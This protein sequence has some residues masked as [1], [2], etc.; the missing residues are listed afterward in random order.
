MASRY[1]NIP[2]LRDESGNRYYQNVI[3]PKIP[4]TA[5]DIYL[6][7]TVGDRYDK[8]AQTYY[9]DPTLWWIIASAN[10]FTTASL[11][12]T[13]GTQLRIPADKNKVIQLFQQVNNR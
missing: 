13:P 4:E 9:Q 12:P 5:D 2:I 11:I 1:K 6:I 8:L 7:S 3:Y 10:N